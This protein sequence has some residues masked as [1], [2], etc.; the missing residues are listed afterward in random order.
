MLV[1]K[2]CSLKA[3]QVGY[4]TG[5]AFHVFKSFLRTIQLERYSIARMQHAS[6]C[7][8]TSPVSCIFANL[9][10]NGTWMYCCT[11]K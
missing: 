11:K 3:V 10:Y 7:F 9:R 6:S 8:C 5:K 1:Y 2:K 4:I